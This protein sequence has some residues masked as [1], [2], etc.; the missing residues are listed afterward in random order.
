MKLTNSINDLPIR[1]MDEIDTLLKC[2]CGSRQS[3]PIRRGDRSFFTVAGQSV[4]IRATVH[5]RSSA[6]V[7]NRS[8]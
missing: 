4:N 1:P 5:P 6:T 8:I 3:A 2:H 7:C